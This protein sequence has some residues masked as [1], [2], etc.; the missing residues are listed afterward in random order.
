[1]AAAARANARHLGRIDEVFVV[2]L[3]W[4]LY[5]FAKQ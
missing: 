1:M 4:F 5:L 3:W 2:Q